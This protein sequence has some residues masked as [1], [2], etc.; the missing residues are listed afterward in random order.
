MRGFAHLAKPQ[1][2]MNANGRGRFR[3]TLRALLVITVCAGCLAGW[4]ARVEQER[5]VQQEVV[6]SLVKLGAKI[7]YTGG[8]V[9]EVSLFRLGVDDADLKLL[10]RLRHI[11]VL[12]IG[13]NRITDEGLKSVLHLRKLRVL[14]LQVTHV[15]DA[16]VASLELSLIHI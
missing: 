14:T 13:M 3:F 2:P 6:E 15:S 16:G 4:Y 12:H 11:E 10:E 8:N 1:R 9:S 7:Q 5:R